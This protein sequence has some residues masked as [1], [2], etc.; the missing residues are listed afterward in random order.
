MNILALAKWMKHNKSKLRLTEV[1]CGH[2]VTPYI[3]IR[4][5][6]S[7]WDVIENSEDSDLNTVL[8]LIQKEMRERVPAL[9]QKKRRKKSNEETATI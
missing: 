3:S 1:S 6:S 5:E 4:V 2:E 9:V 8:K 7:L